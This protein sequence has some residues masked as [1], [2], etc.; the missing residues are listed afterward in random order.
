MFY[1]L[2]GNNKWKESDLGPCKMI[3]IWNAYLT[4]LKFKTCQ[5]E[6]KFVLQRTQGE[7]R[8]MTVHLRTHVIIHS[9]EKSQNNATTSHLKMHIQHLPRRTKMCVTNDREEMTLHVPTLTYNVNLH[10]FCT[11]V[12]SMLT[13]MVPVN[14]TP[15]STTT[16]TL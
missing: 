12:N 3:P 4:S 2:T 1:Q 5:G 15:P 6:P 16:F 8:E 7:K 14:S 9:M 13:Y 10:G 11:A